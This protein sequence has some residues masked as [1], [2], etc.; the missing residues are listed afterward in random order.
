[1]LPP[2]IILGTNFLDVADVVVTTPGGHSGSNDAGFYS[3]TNVVTGGS[4]GRTATTT[5]TVVSATQIEA[6]TSAG[7]PGV[8][9]IIVTT[10]SNNSGTTGQKL[11]TC[12]DGGPGKTTIGPQ[13]GLRADDTIT[14]T[15]SNFVPGTNRNGT[16]A[17]TGSIGGNPAAH[18]QVSAVKLIVQVP[19][20]ITISTSVRTQTAD[21]DP[22]IA[23]RRSR[24]AHP[25]GASRISTSRTTRSGNSAPRPATARPPTPTSADTTFVVPLSFS[26]FTLAFDALAK[27]WN[28]S[29]S[30]GCCSEYL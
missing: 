20:N 29:A 13:I 5:F 16:T 19:A 24:A 17:T 10:A 15:G 8:A 7:I 14:I 26:G 23:G 1:V 22:G 21:A 4:V 9:D 18:V 12:A 3:F 25:P 27:E 28:I 11:L 6:F 30:A 2:I